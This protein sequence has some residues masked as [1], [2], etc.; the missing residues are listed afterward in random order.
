MLG[1]GQ[2][3]GYLSNFG[4]VPY[5]ETHFEEDEDGIIGPECLSTV[6]RRLSMPQFSPF[7]S[8]DDDSVFIEAGMSSLLDENKKIIRTSMMNHIESSDDEEKLVQ[9]LQKK[10]KTMNKRKRVVLKDG[11]TTV[12]YKNISKKRRRYFSDLYTTLLDSSWTYCVLLLLLS[13]YGSWS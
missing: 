2:D 7:E 10:H 13:F 3:S 5:E 8:K 11:L 12:T 9:N 1:N 4:R 6:N